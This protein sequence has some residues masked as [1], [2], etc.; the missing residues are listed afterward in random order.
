MSHHLNKI[1]AVWDDNAE[2]LASDI[3]E[4]GVTVR[5]WRNRGDIP[6]RSAQLKI[7]RAAYDKDG[8]VLKLEDFLSPEERLGLPG[9]AVEDMGEGPDP[10]AIN[11]GDRI[12]AEASASAS[13]NNFGE[14]ICSEIGADNSGKIIGLAGEADSHRP[15]SDSPPT[16]STTREPSG[17]SS[18]PA[19]STGGAE[20]A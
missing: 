1:F 17:Q 19:S 6:S 7:I 13:A 15:F 16:C 3:D 5:Q 12:G 4:K 18:S 10:S 14:N 11:G 9:H 20:A 8:T 2:A